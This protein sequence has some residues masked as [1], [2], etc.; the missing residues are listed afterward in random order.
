LARFQLQQPSTRLGGGLL[1]A[2]LATLGGCFTPPPLF[3][4]DHGAG[5]SEDP[6]ALL[7]QSTP[8]TQLLAIDGEM[9]ALWQT[10]HPL[11]IAVREAMGGDRP[12][13]VELRALHTHDTLYVLA[14]WP[15]TTPSRQRDPYAWNP[16][17]QEYVKETRADDQFALEFPLDGDFAISMLTANREYS[18][19]VWHWQAGRGNLAGW[20][21]DKRHIISQEP[22]QNAKRYSL[23]SGRS[24][25]VARLADS[26]RSSYRLRPAP[27][28]R[29]DD[30][31]D[32]LL[33]QEPSGSR[34]DVRAKGQHR[35]GVW[36]LELRRRFDTGYDDDAVIDPTG[37][38]PCAIAVLNDEL[39]EEHS[40]SS[41]L[42]LRFAPPQELP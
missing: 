1:V 14:R 24:V 13:P 42:N 7:W 9:E 38:N 30:R 15:D 10:A 6:E 26:G 11:V 37:D 29:Q 35:D 25:Y 5:W 16:R 39:H 33:P 40:V 20:A 17:T 4:P 12:I 32:S 21:E 2:L 22:V 27:L 36:T 3:I 28:Q 41:L 8:I 19:D 23:Y 31:V 34:A 18:A